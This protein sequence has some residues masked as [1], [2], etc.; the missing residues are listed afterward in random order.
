[1]PIFEFGFFNHFIFLFI[2]FFFFFSVFD[3]VVIEND[4]LIKIKLE[5]VY[6]SN[7]ISLLLLFMYIVNSLSNLIICL[8]Q[9]LRIHTGEKPYKCDRSWT[10]ASKN[11][12]TNVICRLQQHLRILT[13]NKPNKRDRS[14]ISSNNTYWRQAQQV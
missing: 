1:M 13:G 9:H 11:G 8:Q 7:R 3:A 4:S 6:A 12:P 14:F 2:Y 10:T 5:E